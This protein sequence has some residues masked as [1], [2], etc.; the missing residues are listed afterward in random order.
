MKSKA[1][2]KRV[3][4]ILNGKVA[5][6]DAFRAAINRQRTAGHRIEVRLT[7][8]KGDA[9]RFV[10]EAGEVD[11]IIAAGGDGTLNEVVHALMDISE[12]ARP[13]LGIVPLGQRFRDR[14]RHSA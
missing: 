14:M 6:N 1:R 7:W 8:E 13:M 2:S 11:L 5:A 10:S 3:R 9:R 12:T 4:L